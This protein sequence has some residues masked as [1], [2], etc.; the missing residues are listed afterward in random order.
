M[1]IES[2]TDLAYFFETDDFGVAANFTSPALGTVNGI[3]D[4]E[5]IEVE[6]GGEVGI[7][8]PQPTFKCRTSDLTGVTEASAVTIGSTNYLVKNRL[9]DGTG[10]TELQ[11]EEA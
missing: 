11:L 10:T 3:F 9:D 7:L 1:A 2:G 4:A 6:M 5:V 8:A